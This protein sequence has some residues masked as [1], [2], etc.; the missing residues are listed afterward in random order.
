MDSR[1]W[2]D[3]LSAWSL[4][5]VQARSGPDADDTVV[6]FARARP[7]ARSAAAL[8]LVDGPDRRGYLR[9]AGYTVRTYVAARAPGGAIVLSLPRQHLP[10]AHEP[11]ALS[12][13]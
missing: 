10:N 5:R 7:A 9:R 13:G 2:S 3:A 8:L 1:R 12:G 6:V 4:R 11:G